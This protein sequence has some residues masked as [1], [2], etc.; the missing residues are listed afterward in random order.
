MTV[1][2]LLEKGKEVDAMFDRVQQAIEDCRSIYEDEGES[3]RFAAAK[4]IAMALHRE[5][6]RL[7]QEHI[8]LCK[9][10]K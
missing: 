5:H 4:G 10:Y 7:A 6:E 2:E 1:N 3:P 9:K 8:D